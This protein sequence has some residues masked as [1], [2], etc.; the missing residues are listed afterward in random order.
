MNIIKL[1]KQRIIDHAVLWRAMFQDTRYANSITLTERSVPLPIPPLFMTPSL[2]PLSTLATVLY[3]E[4][5]DFEHLSVA[6]GKCYSV[7]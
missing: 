5:K 7:R 2:V 6:R 1:D 3:H 4:M